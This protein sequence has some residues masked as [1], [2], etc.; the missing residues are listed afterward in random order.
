MLPGK[1]DA[2]LWEE[3]QISAAVKSLAELALL[4]SREKKTQKNNL[5]L[6]CS[7]F[8]I[9]LHY[10]CV[11]MRAQILCGYVWS[12]RGHVAVSNSSYMK[13]RPGKIVFGAQCWVGG[14]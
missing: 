9:H 10:T 1:N 14:C 5:C 11:R 4:F 8:H 3:Q 12:V 2:K 7:L 13:S 6:S